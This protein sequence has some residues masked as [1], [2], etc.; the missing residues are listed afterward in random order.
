MNPAPSILSGLQAVA[1][2][3]VDSRHRPT[4]NCRHFAQGE[5][6]GPAAGLAICR[7]SNGGFLL[8]GCDADWNAVTDTWHKTLEDALH[9]AEFEYDGV[10]ETWSWH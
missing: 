6:V 5:L 10:D 4:G 9:Q 1:W 7:E 3:V 2:T 8:F